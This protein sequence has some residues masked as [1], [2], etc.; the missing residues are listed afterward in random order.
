VPERLHEKTPR[1]AE[2]R[3]EQV[4]PHQLAADRNPRLAE[5]AGAPLQRIRQR[6]ARQRARAEE[7][8][9]VPARERAR[10][11]AQ[12]WAHE[13]VREYRRRCGDPHKAQCVTNA[14]SPLTLR[15][16]EKPE[17]PTKLPST[18][19]VGASGLKASCRGEQAACYPSQPCSDL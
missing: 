14:I 11:E 9:R 4:D 2:R 18:A 7:R 6:A 8:K 16:V 15:Q 12:E 5:A 3:D 10:G 17:R 19:A 13:T 1:I